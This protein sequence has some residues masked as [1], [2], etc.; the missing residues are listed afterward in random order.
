MS[1]CWVSP[2]TKL[3]KVRHFGNWNGSQNPKQIE[4][5]ICWG[6]CFSI[7][8]KNKNKNCNYNFITLTRIQL[9]YV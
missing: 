5:K 7:T 1:T 8:L 9:L 4:G 2:K 6:I 3:N